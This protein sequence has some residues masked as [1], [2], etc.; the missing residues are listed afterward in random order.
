MCQIFKDYGGAW[1]GCRWGDRLIL[2][3]LQFYMHNRYCS[4]SFFII[5]IFFFWNLNSD[6]I[7]YSYRSCFLASGKDT[8]PQ[9]FSSPYV[10]NVRRCN[11]NREYNPFYR[12]NVFRINIYLWWLFCFCNFTGLAHFSTILVNDGLMW[13]LGQFSSSW[14]VFCCST[15]LQLHRSLGFICL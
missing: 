13:Y 12:I 11:L 9:F 14:G 1:V 8:C 7:V 6:E 3:L 2:L 15:A 4:C 10:K 5:I